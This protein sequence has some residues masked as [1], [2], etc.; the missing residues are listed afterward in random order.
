MLIVTSLPQKNP[1][2]DYC[3][4]TWKDKG[5]DILAV[6]DVIRPE[7]DVK[8]LIGNSSYLFPNRPT[9]SNMVEI[10]LSYSPII[11]ILNSDIELQGNI[12]QKKGFGIRW[13]Y[14]DSPEESTR[15][16]WGI[17]AFI[18][19]ERI[20]E[21]PLAIGKP[22]WDYWLME[23]VKDC[24]WHVEKIFFHKH[25]KL[26]WNADDWFKGMNWFNKTFGTNYQS[27]QDT[28]EHRLKFP[29]HF[30]WIDPTFSCKHLINNECNIVR[31]LAGIPYAP[32]PEN[33]RA[34]SKCTKPQAINEIT[35]ACADRILQQHNEPPLYYGKGGP[36]T[37]LKTILSWFSVES[38]TCKCAERAELMNVWGYEK[39]WSNRDIILSW[40]RESALDRNVIYSDWV[41][42]R[43]LYLI[44]H[45]K[46][47]PNSTIIES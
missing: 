22:W 8:Q 40:L 15:E 11:C 19:T 31:Q 41:L 12:P 39:C 25:H 3:V 42:K 21:S 5:Y 38:S 27:K 6:Q 4:G 2:T 35:K 13:N 17:D 7:Y 32:P 29:Y 47:S 23:V 20:P 26:N 45:I 46:T 36:G 43:L 16:E 30:D 37:R 44:C 9:L 28:I 10:G 14:V 34:C 33:C 18:T 24:F 1:R